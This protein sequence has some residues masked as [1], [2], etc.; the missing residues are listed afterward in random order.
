[1]PRT[2]TFGELQQQLGRGLDGCVQCAGGRYR[3]AKTPGMRCPR[4]HCPP[5]KFQRDYTSCVCI[6]GAHADKKA[7]LLLKS[8]QEQQEQQQQQQRRQRQQHYQQPTPAPS[9]APRVTMFA[10]SAAPTPESRLMAMLRERE[11]VR[12]L[13]HK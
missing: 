12:A 10:T 2:A 1:M 8:Q 4:C 7:P 6:K 3:A 13:E 11:R 5:G 9:H